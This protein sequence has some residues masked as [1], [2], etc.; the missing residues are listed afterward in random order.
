[1]VKYN[2]N[3]LENLYLFVL[4]EQA[5]VFRHKSLKIEVRNLSIIEALKEIIDSGAVDRNIL[6][7]AAVAVEF[8]QTC[9]ECLKQWYK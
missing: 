7:S 6:K 8:Y 5:V 2:E 1:M 9:D 4:H 3:V